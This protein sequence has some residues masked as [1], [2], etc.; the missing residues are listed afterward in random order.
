M[1]FDQ[2][3]DRLIGAEGGYVNNPADPG[4]ETQWG[5]SKRAYPTLDI[6]ALTRDAA[7]AIYLNDV[8]ARARLDQLA[9]ALAFQVFD[10]AVNHGAEGATRMLQRAAYGQA[11]DAGQATTVSSEFSRLMEPSSSRRRTTWM[12]VSCEVST[13]RNRTGPSIEISSRR[14]SAARFEIEA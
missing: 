12:M 13:S 14:L 3:F 2:A 6:K 4:G 9:P 5:I 11:P 8:W 10:A 7:K 1:N